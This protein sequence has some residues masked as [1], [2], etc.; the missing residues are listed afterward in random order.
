MLKNKI[1]FKRIRNIIILGLVIIIM[2]GIYNNSVRNSR[3]ENVQAIDV[4]F[5]DNESDTTQQ[6]ANATVRVEA[7]VNEDGTYTIPLNNLVNGKAVTKY[8]G[9]DEDGIAAMTQTQLVMPAES[10]VD[11]QVQIR[12]DY[13]KKTVTANDQTLVIYKQTLTASP[14]TITGYVPNETPI[15]VTDIDESTLVDVELPNTNAQIKDAYDIELQ[16]YQ[17]VSFGEEVDVKILNATVTEPIVYHLPDGGKEIEEIDCS[18]EGGYVTFKADEFSTYIIASEVGEEDDTENENTTNTNTTTDTNTTNPDTNTTPDEPTDEPI[19]EPEEEEPEIV[20]DAAEVGDTFTVGSATYKIT[21]LTPNLEVELVSIDKNYSGEFT[22]PETVQPNLTAIKTEH[23]GNYIDLGNNVV[24]KNKTTDDWRILHVDKTNNVVYAILADYLPNTTGYAE[25]VALTID[26]KYNVS[27]NREELLSGLKKSTWNVLANGINGA[28]VTGSPTIEMIVDGYNAKNNKGLSYDT[29]Q[30]IENTIT[31]YSLYVPHAEVVESASGYWLANPATDEGT[32]MFVSYNGQ[33]NAVS[34]NDTYM[35]IRPVVALPTILTA[36]EKSNGWVV[37]TAGVDIQSYK[38]TSIANG[39]IENCTGLTSLVVPS[40][41]ITIGTRG[42]E[43]CSSLVGINVDANNEKYLSESGVLFDKTKT[44]LLKYP[45]GKVDVSYTIPNTVTKVENSAFLNAKVSE[46]TIPSSVTT[47]GTNAFVGCSNL[48]KIK[49]PETVTTFGQNVFAATTTMYVKPNSTAL[50]YATENSHSHVVMT[51]PNWTKVSGTVGENGTIIFVV[52]GN[53]TYDANVTSTLKD[54]NITVLIDGEEANVNMTISE[55]T[56]TET[57]IT[58]TITLSN[59]NQ[60]QK[61]NGKEYL[62]WSGDVSLKI[63]AGTLTDE[64]GL[65]S[66]EKTIE[67]TKIDQIKPEIEYVK[68]ESGFAKETATLQLKFRVIDK[69]FSDEK[70]TIEKTI[71]AESSNIKVRV[72]G[73]ELAATKYKI[74]KQGNITAIVNGV[75]KVVGANYML[76]ATGLDTLTNNSGNV[77]LVFLAGVAKDETENGNGIKT[78]SA[79]VDKSDKEIVIDYVRPTWTVSGEIK[80]PTIATEKAVI[81]I[82]GTDN[83]LKVEESNLSVND[84]EVYLDGTI[85]DDS[86]ISRS[87]S[88]KD[89]TSV[90]NGVRYTLTLGNFENTSGT[91]TVKI[92]DNS[93]IDNAGNQNEALPINVG[94]IDFIKP[95]WNLY[96]TITKPTTQNGEV[97]III[98]GTDKDLNKTNSNLALENIKVYVNDSEVNASTVTRNLSEKDIT[99]VA[100]GVRYTLTLGGF[101]TVSG[102]IR[103]E[104]PANSLEDNSSNKNEAYP[105]NVGYVDVIKP[106]WTVSGEIKKPTTATEKAIITIDG[107][108]NYLKVEESNLSVSD[109]EVYLDGTIVDDSV[110]SRSLSA[111]DTTSVANGVRYTLTLGN[112]E[113]TSGT[114]TVKILENNLIDNAGNQ[115][116][117]LP[118]NVGKIDFIKPEWNVHGTITKPTTPSGELKITIDGRDKDLNKTDSNLVLG[119]IKVYINDVIADE[120]AVTRSLSAKDTTSVANGIRYTLTLGN[121]EA[122]SGDIKVEIPANSLIDNSSNK[123]EVYTIDVGTVDVIKPIWNLDTEKTVIDAVNKKVT[124]T[125]VGQDDYLKECTLT[126]SNIKVY[127]LNPDGSYSQIN[128]TPTIT[129]TPK[130]ENGKV[131]VVVEIACQDI[132]SELF[133]EL[134]ANTLVDN[135]GNKDD[136][137]GKIS[138]GYSDFEK[139]VI[140]KI[141]SSINRTN[142]TVSVNVKITDEY[143]LDTT[144]SRGIQSSDITI[145]RNGTALDASVVN[146]ITSIKNG[147]RDEKSQVY[148]ITFNLDGYDGIITFAINGGVM[149]DTF[150]NVTDALPEIGVGNIAWVE[151]GDDQAAPKYTAF[152]ENLVDFTLPSIKYQSNLIIDKG[153]QTATIVFDVLEEHLKSNVLEDNLSNVASLKESLKIFIDTENV[154][155]VLLTNLNTTLV[156]EDITGGKRYTLTLAGFDQA[157][158]KVKDYSGTIQLEFAANLIADTSG[159]KNTKTS[160]TLDSGDGSDISNLVDVIKPTWRVTSEKINSTMRDDADNSVEITLVGSDKFLTEMPELI[161]VVRVE[162]YDGTSTNGTLNRDVVKTFSTPKYTTNANGIKEVTTVLKLTNFGTYTNNVTVK[163]LENTLI[164]SSNNTN[165]YI[166]YTTGVVDYGELIVVPEGVKVDNEAAPTKITYTFSVEDP[167]FASSLLTSSTVNNYITVYVDGEVVTDITKTL[168]KVD[169]TNGSGTTSPSTYTVM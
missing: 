10:V 51:I 94:K 44:N 92:S 14:V 33:I 39:A 24:G 118:I 71:E 109:I 167:Y 12:T 35:A 148:G 142:K 127:K 34:T 17:P 25:D 151:Q 138:I 130:V 78:I 144:N 89:T 114:I 165:D 56:V 13:D 147:T 26:G 21:S 159:N 3:A 95:E 77:D 102:D 19:E 113:N 37:G 30:N 9:V 58:Q 137:K 75:S 136:A 135:S 27:A 111:K 60:T 32:V 150:G 149:Q 72:N 40:S 131:T 45:A 122:T 2:L 141:D 48:S 53:K 163:I 80:K 168:S 43:N 22:I 105:I 28:T 162:V 49:V 129:N 134:D 154:T 36:T 90:A 106:I 47:L 145:Y 101:G 81:T 62:E 64:N 8:Y 87:L 70:S 79:V 112:F 68:S 104:I 107:T 98:D 20:T 65:T 166:T 67:P 120:N 160:I 132:S 156:S 123:N 55:P 59:L 61:Q 164:D 46:V 73:Q 82:D 108:D 124:V 38:V 69:Y 140:E 23:I 11:G 117:A 18:H 16:G 29:E 93:L 76:E 99:S 88:A 119:N 153:A 169:I 125:L 126:N 103:V 152:R 128:V 63:P 7:I 15:N 74:F 85:V 139:P 158:N 133:I 83:Y 91:I 100:N 4:V 157:S 1:A 97:K 115:N 155:E 86:V 52:S 161:D 57:G 96:G 50:A 54:S 121:F 84:I 110:I 5:V 42:I 116:E 31:D 143:K 146:S 66:A 6:L 41:I